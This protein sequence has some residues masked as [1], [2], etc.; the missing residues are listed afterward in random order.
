MQLW[1]WHLFESAESDRARMLPLAR[2]ERETEWTGGYT[3]YGPENERLEGL[4]RVS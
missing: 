4:L 2:V 3:F 1:D